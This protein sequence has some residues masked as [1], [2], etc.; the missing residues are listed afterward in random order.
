MALLKAYELSVEGPGS[1]ELIVSML[2]FYFMDELAI[3]VGS[4]LIGI[5][6]KW[7][8]EIKEKLSHHSIAILNL[9]LLGS[10]KYWW[11]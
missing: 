7:I 1:F 8:I 9:S 10:S 4:M 3:V 11:F 5:G 6:A 2:V